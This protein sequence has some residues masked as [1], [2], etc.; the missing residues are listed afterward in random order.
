MLHRIH[1]LHLRRIDFFPL[2]GRILRP[3][4]P[5]LLIIVFKFELGNWLE[6]LLLGLFEF[7]RQSLIV[8]LAA[9][10]IVRVFIIGLGPGFE[11]VRR[12][13]N[14]LLV[15]YVCPHFSSPLLHLR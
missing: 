14:R 8:A 2:G 12:E 10:L 9:N 5:V 3:V 7:T 13:S 6:R 11:V 1:E 15:E 4:V